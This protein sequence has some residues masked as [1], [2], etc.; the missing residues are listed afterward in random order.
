VTVGRLTELVSFGESWHSNHHAFPG[1]AKFSVEPG[2]SDLGWDVLQWFKRRGWAWNLK[3]QA[4][5]PPRPALQDL[6]SSSHTH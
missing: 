6:G 5:L 2:Q 3:T 4:D 1:S